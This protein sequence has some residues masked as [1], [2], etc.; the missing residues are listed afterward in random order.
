MEVHQGHLVELRVFLVEIETLRLADIGTSGN[1]KV[2]HLLLADLPDCLVDVFDIL[3][4]LLDGLH[5]S[6]V[7]ND[8]VLD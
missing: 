8:L 4:N 7:C 5:T 1:G 2:H 6:V 3:R